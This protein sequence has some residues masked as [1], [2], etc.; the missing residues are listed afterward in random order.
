V[1]RKT[2]SMKKVNHASQEKECE[3]GGCAGITGFFEK[4]GYDQKVR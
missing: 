3:S 1:K 4:E 2:L